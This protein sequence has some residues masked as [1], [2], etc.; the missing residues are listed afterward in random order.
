MKIRIVKIS[1]RVIFIVVVV[2]M[3]MFLV[4]TF[5]NIIPVFRFN[6]EEPIYKGDSESKK[7][8][9]ACNVYWGNEYIPDMLNIFRKNDIKITFFIGGSWSR[10][11]PE[12]LKMIYDEGHEIGNH[13]YNHKDHTKLAFEENKMEIIRAEKQIEETTG[14]KTNLFAPPSGA[15]NKDTIKAAKELG[16]TVIMWSIDTIDWKK[17]GSQYIIDKVINNSHNGAIVLMHPVED[18]LEALPSIIMG[19]KAQGYEITNVSEVIANKNN[20]Q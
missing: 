1:K 7:I 14:N 2:L 18:T 5:S 6:S 3:I 13:G 12:L 4:K 19:L 8:A 20:R 17:P 11:F 15:Y 9:F 10:D 16:Y